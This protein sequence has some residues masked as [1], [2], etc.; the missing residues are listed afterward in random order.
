MRLAAVT[1]GDLSRQI[2]L[3][4]R[5]GHVCMQVNLFVLDRSPE[6]LDEHVVAPTASAVHADAMPFLTRT[7]MKQEFVNGLL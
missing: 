1:E 5:D 4:F 6:A 7:P 3:G 2:R